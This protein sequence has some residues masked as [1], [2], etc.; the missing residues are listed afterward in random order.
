M[1]QIIPAAVVLAGSYL[2]G[3]AAVRVTHTQCW[4]DHRTEETG[5]YTFFDTWSNT[6]MLLYR[7]FYPLLVLDSAVSGRSFEKDKW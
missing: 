2:G 6:D 1:R 5:T 4:F 3:Y 7:A